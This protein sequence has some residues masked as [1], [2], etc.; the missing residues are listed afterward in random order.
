MDCSKFLKEAYEKFHE[1]NISMRE[2]T[3]LVS[4]DNLLQEVWEVS[5][6]VKEVMNSKVF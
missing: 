2:A 6:K 4:C 5:S 1:G 3:T